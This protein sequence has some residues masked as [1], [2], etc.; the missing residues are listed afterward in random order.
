MR[1]RRLCGVLLCGAL[2]LAA[3]GSRG[4]GRVAVPEEGPPGTVTVYGRAGAFGSLGTTVPS[5]QTASTRAV[6]GWGFPP[7]VMAGRVIGA[8]DGTLVVAG[9]TQSWEGRSRSAQTV[10]TTF[11]PVARRSTT[12]RVP[13]TTGETSVR[14]PAGALA[15]GSVRGLVALGGP[16][17]AVAFTVRRS[18]ADPG[19]AAERTWPVLGVLTRDGPQ[20]T[21]R[22]ENVRSAAGIDALDPGTCADGSCA[23]FGDLAALPASGR[24]VAA[25]ADPPGLRV[26]RVERQPGSGDYV[27]RMGAHYPFPRMEGLRVAP[28]EVHADPTGVEGDERFVVGLDVT[29]P[30]GTPRAPVLQAFTLSGEGIRPTT[31]PLIPGTRSDKKELPFVGYG[32][33]RYDRDGNLW[34]AR[35]SNLNGGS[36]ALY[37]PGGNLAA[38]RPDGRPAGDY[39]T[40][41]AD[42]AQTWGVACRP[43][44]D[45]VQANRLVGMTGLIP[46]PDTGVMVAL[47]LTGTLMSVRVSGH[48]PGMTFRMGTP[49][50]LGRVL[51][52]QPTPL[53][54]DSWPGV[55]AAGHTLWIAAY[56]G[57]GS[58]DEVTGDQYL[59]AVR[60]SDLFDP[61][62]V[63]LSG[64]PGQETVVQLERTRTGTTRLRAGVDATV[65]VDPDAYFGHCAP[66]PAE[67]GCGYDGVPGNDFILI[68]DTGFGHQGGPI[69]I[70]VHVAVAG[71]Y[72]VVYR[73]WTFEN[74]PNAAV[75]LEVAGSTVVTP[76]NTNGLWRIV[77][78]PGTVDLPAGPQVLR[79][80]AP[81]PARRGWGMSW[82]GFQRA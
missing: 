35:H 78:V 61:P 45:L 19:P 26:M 70:P 69:E 47:T 80:S 23:A 32:A 58:R 2:V 33:L 44:F 71:R 9:V 10:L 43:D 17:D 42:G 49:V 64:L 52:P 22:P 27:V 36:L 20:W 76:V 53:T 37:F 63:P 56:Q 18:V 8:G 65:D 16:D 41:G 81:S 14:T 51:L 21:V 30:D 72:R 74:V 15:G 4:P 68:D 73:V 29:A 3:A 25:V 38:C 5:G 39:R 48:G 31:P 59:Y 57:D 50:D 62:P 28:R 1:V 24:L 60:L 40:R 34:A 82:I 55:V 12:V 7:G 75:R 11:D 6:P 77:A 46:D 13:T 67:T 54:G 66:W 79:L